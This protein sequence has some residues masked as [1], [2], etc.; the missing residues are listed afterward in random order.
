[1]R[2]SIELRT[3]TWGAVILTLQWV[4][5]QEGYAS[6]LAPCVAEVWKRFL[7]NL[8]QKN[9]WNWTDNLTHVYTAI[10]DRVSGL[11][12]R[13]ARLWCNS[14]RRRLGV[15]RRSTGTVWWGKE[16]G[17][18]F[19]LKHVLGI[20]ESDLGDGRKDVN[21]EGRWWLRR[22]LACWQRGESIWGRVVGSWAMGLNAVTCR[23]TAQSGNA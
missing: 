2:R 9:W 17:S 12:I 13:P 10:A 11:C 16:S 8:F 19:E 20:V 4:M 3:S 6:A 5:S 21:D 23:A 22:L 18:G 7:F 15:D 1:M 14:R